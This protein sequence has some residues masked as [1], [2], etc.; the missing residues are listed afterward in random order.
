M[1]LVKDTIKQG[2]IDACTAVMDDTSDDRTG[3]LDRVAEGYAQAVIAAIKS[4]KIT[5][6]GGLI[7]ASG[8]V[9]GQFGCTI[10]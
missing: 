10:Q 4:M 1:A 8:P 6:T 5:Y 2:F 9:T 7:A 3:A